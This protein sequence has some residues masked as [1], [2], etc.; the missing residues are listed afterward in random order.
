MNFFLDTED[1]TLFNSHVIQMGRLFNCDGFIQYS[2]FLSMYS[3]GK[4]I[5]FFAVLVSEIED[6][7]SFPYFSGPLCWKR[8]AVPWKGEVAVS[9]LE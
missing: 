6:C 9:E 5:N 3:L 7:L 8:D 2:R 4:V 1:S